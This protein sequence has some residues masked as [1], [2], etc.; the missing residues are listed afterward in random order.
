MSRRNREED[1]CSRGGHRHRRSE[2]N[3]ARHD[4]D[5]P[6]AQQSTAEPM[7]DDNGNLIEDGCGGQLWRSAF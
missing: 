7:F 4:G 5:A 6:D 1:V 2:R 3:R